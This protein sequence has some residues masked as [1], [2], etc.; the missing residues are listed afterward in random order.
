MLRIE[1]F[2]YAAFKVYYAMENGD[3]FYDLFVDIVCVEVVWKKNMQ[4]WFSILKI[5]TV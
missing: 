2:S 4:I 5:I 3:V 1:Q